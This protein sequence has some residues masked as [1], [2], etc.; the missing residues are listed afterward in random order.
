MLQTT[1]IM[2]LWTD[3]ARWMAGGAVERDFTPPHPPGREWLRIEGF[4]ACCRRSAE[5]AFASRYGMQTR[6]LCVRVNLSV[7]SHLFIQ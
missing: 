1:E 3:G 7:L 6:L 4:G 2:T 5:G